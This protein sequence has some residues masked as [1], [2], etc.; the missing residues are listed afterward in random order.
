[1]C[2]EDE[3][4]DQTGETSDRAH[5]Q[6]QNRGRD[7]DAE[8]G[9]NGRLAYQISRTES[10][11]VSRR[12]A[13]IDPDVQQRDNKSRAKQFPPYR[14]E[15]PEDAGV[16]ELPHPQPFLYPV[17]DEREN[18]DDRDRSNNHQ[19]HWVPSP[20]EEVTSVGVRIYVRKWP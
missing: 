16:A 3:R 20:E 10:G 8:F 17:G 7:L 13:K 12:K 5:G 1:L 6:F 15:C 2:I 14:Q 9:G 4:K 11:A 19:P 18:S